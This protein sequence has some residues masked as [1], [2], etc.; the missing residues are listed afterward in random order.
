ME[1]IENTKWKVDAAHSE[2][3]FK[4][5]HMMISTV[6]GNLKGFD[7]NIETDKENFKDADFSFTAKMDSISTNNKEKYAHLKSADFLNN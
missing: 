5:K 1:T 3:G 2:I 7:A 4:I 6:S